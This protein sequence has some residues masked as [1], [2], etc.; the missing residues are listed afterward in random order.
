MR[1]IILILLVVVLSLE[2]AALFIAA[3]KLQIAKAENNQLVW[4]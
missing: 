3:P 2:I 4:E 1:H